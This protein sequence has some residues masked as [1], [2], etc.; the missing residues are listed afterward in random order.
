VLHIFLFSIFLRITTK[1]DHC[2]FAEEPDSGPY[3]THLGVGSSLKELRD[4]MERRTGVT[5]RAL[6]IEK[7]R[8]NAK[9]V[10][11]QRMV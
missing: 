9:H 10:I 3:Y 8:Y 6:R 11:C 1:I 4:T 2:L 5:G 7:C